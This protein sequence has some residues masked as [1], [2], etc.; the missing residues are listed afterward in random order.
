VLDLVASNMAQGQVS[1]LSNWTG[2]LVTD[3]AGVSAVFRLFTLENSNAFYE[4][5]FPLYIEYR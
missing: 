5:R 2:A 3:G 1:V 4:F